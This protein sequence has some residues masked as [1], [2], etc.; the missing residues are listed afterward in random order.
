MRTKKEGTMRYFLLLLLLAGCSSNIALVLDSEPDGGADTDT[1]TDSDSDSDCDTDTGDPYSDEQYSA[2][3][4]EAFGDGNWDGVSDL[5]TRQDG[6]VVAI[7]H[8]GRITAFEP[9][10]NVLFDRE[11]CTSAECSNKAVDLIGADEFVV[12]G[13]FDGTAV[14]GTGEALETTLVSSGNLSMFIARYDNIG[15]LLWAKKATGAAEVYGGGIGALFDGSIVVTGKIQPGDGS[16]PQDVIFGAGEPN[17][18]AI[19]SI[20]SSS[21]G[22]TS[23]YLARYNGDGSFEW[24]STECVGETGREIVAFPDGSFAVAGRFL[25]VAT[26]GAGKPGEVTLNWV[27]IESS[28]NWDLETPVS[29]FLVR[30]NPDGSVVWA[31]Q[32]SST[33]SPLGRTNLTLLA[34]GSIA[35]SG[36]YLDVLG[37]YNGETT[38]VLYAFTEESGNGVVHMSY[39]LFLARYTDTGELQFAV[40][41][42]CEE[43]VKCSTVGSNPIALGQDGIVVSGR[44]NGAVRYG[45]G[46]AAFAVMEMSKPF[47]AVYDYDGELTYLGAF[48]ETLDAA[49]MSGGEV[50]LSESSDDSFFMGSAFSGSFNIP[51]VDD[52]PVTGVALTDSDPFVSHVCPEFL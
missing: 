6:S 30:Y 14:F 42:K 7:T 24:A 29:L 33:E 38:Q 49:E 50:K 3:Y 32:A 37:F 35:V 25:K 21:V 51:I 20:D 12:T 2:C 18:T 1:D 15:D 39:A 22:G 19:T 5:I 34:D 28:I 40:T 10:G 45:N 8:N 43:E 9:N 4:F 27:P 16:F 13:S 44:S 48:G 52:S 46:A 36:T 31:R 47:V 23:A 11:T 26:F 41:T 17:E